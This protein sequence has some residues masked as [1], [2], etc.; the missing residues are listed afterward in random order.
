MKISN[1]GLNLIMKYEGCRLKAYKPVPTETYWTIGYGHYGK[2]V[3]QGMVITH[4]DAIKLLQ[5][6]IKKFENIVNKKN[7]NLTQN[8]FDA[9]VSFT[10]N[11]GESNLDKLIYN[12]SLKQ[13]ADA[14]LKYNKAGGK[15]LNGLVKRRNEERS[16]FLK[17]YKEI[18]SKYQILEELN[19]VIIEEF[20]EKI[21]IGK[22]NEETNTRDIQIK[23]NFE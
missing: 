9:L 16:L 20:I 3:T 12:R 11:C 6:D 22:L 23:W 13:I 15:T 17:D 19:R 14:M 8:M 1:I 5:K 21:Y 10:Y 18:F 2:D 7:L 4:L